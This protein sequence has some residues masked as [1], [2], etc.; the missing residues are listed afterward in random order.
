MTVSSVFPKYQV[1][2]ELASREDYDQLQELWS[3]SKESISHSRVPSALVGLADSRHIHL[4]K[5]FDENQ[6]LVAYFP[7]EEKTFAGIRI[8]RPAFYELT[9]DFIDMTA[10]PEWRED[11]ITIFLDWIRSQEKCVLN[12]VMSDENSSL[13][14]KAVVEDDF[15]V[16]ERGKY[17]Y[18]D[19]PA[20]FED[21]LSNLSRSVRQQNRKLL[22]TYGD[23]M[24][25]E[26]VRGNIFGD[27]LQQAIDELMELH[28]I[29]FPKKTSA[30]L[31]HRAALIAYIEKGMT[32]GAV[33]FGRAREIA[34]GE[35][36]ATS[37]YMESPGFIGLLQNGRRI[38][39]QYDKIGTWVLLKTIEWAINENKT[40]LEFLLGDQEYKRRIATGVRDAVSITYFSSNKA[41]YLFRIRQ[42]FGRFVPSLR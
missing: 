40:R 9:L 33:S 28:N 36:V 7:Y 37:L 29:V 23:S 14:K 18:L 31:P 5:I 13:V 11:V 32:D 38:D 35:V 30:M 41:R 22:R 24:V 8:I 1:S 20:T 15:L 4:F 19:F 2:A 10:L 25:F 21:F 17:Y 6:R 27:E 26:M 39:H 16:E 12:I 3:G 34:T 42:R